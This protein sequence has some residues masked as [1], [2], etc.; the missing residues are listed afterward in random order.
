MWYW[1]GW[2]PKLDL[3]PHLWKEHNHIPCTAYRIGLLWKS[4]GITHVKEL[5]KPLKHQK[6]VIFI[7][8]NS[9]SQWET[10]ILCERR[11]HMLSHSRF[12]ALVHCKRNIQ[13]KILNSRLNCALNPRCLFRWPECNPGCC[14]WEN[15]TS[16]KWICLAHAV[17]SECQK[18]AVFY[19]IRESLLVQFSISLP[20][21]Y[22]NFLWPGWHPQIPSLPELPGI[23]EMQ[24]ELNQKF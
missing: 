24:A 5:C 21:W 22:F 18:V 8:I 7:V 23:W 9:H 16:S 17:R 2:L 19:K 13:I 20:R 12:G 1:A 11:Y 14:P 15:A 3:V 4:N 10:E 6:V